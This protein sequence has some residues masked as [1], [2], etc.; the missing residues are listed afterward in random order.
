MV[1]WIIHNPLSDIHVA[2]ITVIFK[3][4]EIKPVIKRLNKR[5]ESI[6]TYTDSDISRYENAHTILITKNLDRFQI[7]AGT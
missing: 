5:P 1:I 6:S 4:P 3:A 7:H 2:F